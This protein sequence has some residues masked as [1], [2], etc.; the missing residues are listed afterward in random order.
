MKKALAFVAI[1]AAGLIA[2]LVI[3]VVQLRSAGHGPPGGTGVI[4]GVD[5]NV[6]SR[7][8]A[9]IAAVHVREGDVVRAGQ[10]V[11]LHDCTDP[12]AAL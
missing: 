7:I 3:R 5:V 9:R 2:A 6:A 8:A 1:L 10:T 11:A 12:R 4:E